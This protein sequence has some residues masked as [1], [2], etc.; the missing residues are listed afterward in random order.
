M[1][2]N[3]SE[4]PKLRKAFR[5]I[6]RMLDELAAEGKSSI[7]LI[8]A[9][10]GRSFGVLMTTERRREDVQHEKRLAAELESALETIKILEEDNALLDIIDAQNDVL[11]GRVVVDEVS[12]WVAGNTHTSF[13]HPEIAPESN[14]CDG[15]LGVID[16]FL[17]TVLT[18]EVENFQ[19]GE[20]GIEEMTLN[21]VRKSFGQL[22]VDGGDEVK[23]SEFRDVLVR[24]DEP[25]ST[26]EYNREDLQRRISNQRKQI[27][28]LQRQ[29]DDADAMFK[30]QERYADYLYR[31]WKADRDILDHYGIKAT[32]L[33]NFR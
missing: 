23:F 25:D 21:D 13:I 14:C 17:H 31:L 4:D 15:V 26:S 6:E 2:I 24:E 10:T 3:Y 20:P 19:N 27:K 8:N 1:E 33:E 9:E 5:R 32:S 7:G 11:Q 28:L 16:S 29:K 12:S 18:P 22:P 30:D